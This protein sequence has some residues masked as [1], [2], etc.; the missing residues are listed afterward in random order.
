MFLSPKYS[1]FIAINIPKY[2]ESLVFHNTFMRERTDNA[3]NE[4]R[5]TASRRR[6]VATPDNKLS[7]C[8]LWLMEYIYNMVSAATSADKRHFKDSEI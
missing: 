3:S 7:D 4:I 6:A 5:V 8:R 2:S 1:E